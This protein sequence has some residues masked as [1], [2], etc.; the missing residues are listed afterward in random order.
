M[1]NDI[2]NDMK[3]ILQLPGAANTGNAQ[4]VDMAVPQ[5]QTGQIRAQMTVIRA[6]GNMF[7]ISGVGAVS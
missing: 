4:L 5:V 6:N 2:H 3:K 7:R 1:N